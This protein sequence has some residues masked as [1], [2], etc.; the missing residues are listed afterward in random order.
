MFDDTSGELQVSMRN[1]GGEAPTDRIPDPERVP[2]AGG[3]TPE[4][5]GDDAG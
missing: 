1:G 4:T 3:S 2:P 5:D